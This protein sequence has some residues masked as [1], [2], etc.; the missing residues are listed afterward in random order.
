MT[1]QDATVEVGQVWEDRDR[2]EI[3]R[4]GRVVG[5]TETH[6]SIRWIGGTVTR[7]RLDR[8]PKA[9]RLVGSAR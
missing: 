8:L 3:G 1:G 7:V 9:F 4:R 5:L 6:A 2:R